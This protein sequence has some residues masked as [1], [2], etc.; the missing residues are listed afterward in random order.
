MN[1]DLEGR[2]GQIEPLPPHPVRRSIFAVGLT[3]VILG[4]F[5]LMLAI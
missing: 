4:L 3:L 1:R 5:A 2:R